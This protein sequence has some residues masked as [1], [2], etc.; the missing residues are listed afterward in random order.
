MRHYPLGEDARGGR[1]FYFS[2]NNE[3]CRLYRE[4]PPRKRTGKRSDGPDSEAAWETVCATLEEMAAF[5]EKLSASRNKSE[6]SLHTV[7]ANGIFPRLVETANARKRAQEKAAALEAMPK[8]R[9]SRLQV[10]PGVPTAVCE[11]SQE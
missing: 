1:Y 4:E 2:G 5:V 10:G 7:L 11:G 9:S 6:R 8:K 3:D